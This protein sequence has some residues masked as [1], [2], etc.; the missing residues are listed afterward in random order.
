MNHFQS[1]SNLVSFKY[2]CATKLDENGVIENWGYCGPDC[3]RYPDDTMTSWHLDDKTLEEVKEFIL[4]SKL[5][6]W[7]INQVITFF[8][9]RPN[10]A[11]RVKIDKAINKIFPKDFDTESAV[12]IPIRGT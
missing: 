10:M 1:W 7:I 8:V 4:D 5:D 9:L 11:S 2:F 6:K 12:G 3:P